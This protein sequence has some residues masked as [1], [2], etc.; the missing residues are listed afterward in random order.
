[1]NSY[2]RILLVDD[3]K[4]IREA[5][6]HILRESG[7]AIRECENGSDALALFQAEPFPW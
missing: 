1:M 4:D 7:Y 6:A 3:D 5:V 2:M